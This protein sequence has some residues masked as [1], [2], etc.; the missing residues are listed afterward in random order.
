MKKRMVKKITENKMKKIMDRETHHRMV[1]GRTKSLL[2]SMRNSGRVTQRNYE[3]MMKIFRKNNL[4]YINEAFDALNR[5]KS[6][7]QYLKNG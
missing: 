1:N 5:I 6:N 7:K 4:S 3:F 2:R